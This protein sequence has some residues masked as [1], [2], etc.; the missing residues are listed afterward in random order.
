MVVRKRSSHTIPSATDA[1]T[2]VGD[3][4]SISR[5]EMR[6]PAN[7]PPRTILTAT[8][9]VLTY[10]TKYRALFRFFL[11][12]RRNQKRLQ[13]LKYRP[14]SLPANDVQPS[15]RQSATFCRFVCV[16][17]YGYAVGDCFPPARERSDI[18]RFN[19]A[20]GC[21]H[22]ATGGYVCLIQYHIS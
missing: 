14:R 11:E 9:F 15:A 2:V 1:P 7:Q 19:P 13:G 16:T 20:F 4:Y 17:K 10:P 22:I 12:K 6:P 8:T 3:G 5:N 18:G 21:V